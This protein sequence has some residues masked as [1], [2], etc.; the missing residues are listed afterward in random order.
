LKEAEKLVRDSNG[1][2]RATTVDVFDARKLGE[3]VK[4]ADVVVR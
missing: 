4:G 3:L 1:R 2:G